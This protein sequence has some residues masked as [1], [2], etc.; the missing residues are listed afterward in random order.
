MVEDPLPDEVDPTHSWRQV[1]V[2]IKASLI[3][4]N[5]VAGLKYWFRVANVN[6]DGQ[7]DWSNPVGKMVSE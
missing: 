3:V 5:L 4:D 2:T 6:K 7:N 1:A